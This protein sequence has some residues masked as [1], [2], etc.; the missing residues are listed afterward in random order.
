MYE[1]G[2]LKLIR[3]LPTL[4]GNVAAALIGKFGIKS[5]RSEG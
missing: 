5:A 3:L 2:E 1:Y 4:G